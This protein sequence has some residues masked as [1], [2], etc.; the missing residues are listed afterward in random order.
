MAVPEVRADPAE[1]ARLA[2]Q[3]LRSSQQLTEAWQAAQ[4]ALQLESTDAGNTSHGDDL[5]RGH[6]TTTG[7]ADVAF[8][9]LAAVLEGDN[10]RVLRVAFAY[11]QADERAA[12]EFIRLVLDRLGIH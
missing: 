1:L 11:Q 5:I 6:Q 7:A 10:D 4:A 12:A 8:G 2:E 9:R 3:L